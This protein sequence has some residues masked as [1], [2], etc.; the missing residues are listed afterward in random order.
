MINSYIYSDILG[1]QDRI[2]AGYFVPSTPY[3]PLVVGFNSYINISYKKNFSKNTTVIYYSGAFGLFHE[4]HLDV[5]KRANEKANSLNINDYVIVISPTN[6]DYAV[7]KYGLYSELSSNKSRT[8]RI[9]DAIETSNIPNVVIDLNPMLNFISDQNFTD[10]LKYFM[11]V[12]G[13]TAKPVIVTGKDRDYS[14]ISNH[15]N[16]VDSWYMGAEVVC[17]TSDHN[18]EQFIKNRSDLLL[19]IHNENELNIFKKY[20]GEYYETITPIYI[21][22]E[23]KKVSTF[24]KETTI[25]ICK[26]YKDVL[27]YVPVHRHYDTPLSN[28]RH[29]DND[30]SE[31]KGM[32]VVDSDIFSGSTKKFITSQGLDMYA[33][34]DLRGSTDIELLDIDDFKI[35]EFRYPFVDLSSKCSLP[36]FTNDIHQKIRSLREELLAV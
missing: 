7:Q 21:S 30:L 26:D 35:E 16:L 6:S 4:G 17:S 10:L 24:D 23:L 14:S 18:T 27:Q 29:L 11:D 5:V 19:R 25:T 12:N 13:I 15:T 1:H 2:N 8:D 9:V 34:I 3:S 28:P 20:L 33:L 31:Y 36:A 22:D 32:L